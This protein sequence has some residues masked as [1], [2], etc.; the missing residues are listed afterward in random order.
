ML[1]CGPELDGLFSAVLWE[2]YSGQ[3]FSRRVLEIRINRFV[4]FATS[5]VKFGIQENTKEYF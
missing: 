2:L 4:C 3:H 5:V 1:E